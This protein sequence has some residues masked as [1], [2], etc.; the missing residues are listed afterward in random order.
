ALLQLG[1]IRT[2]EFIVLLREVSLYV[3]LHY[4][5]GGAVFVGRVR[6]VQG[7]VCKLMS[8]DFPYRFC[9]IATSCRVQAA[10]LL[11]NFQGCAVSINRTAVARATESPPS[12]W[13]VSKF[14]PP[15]GRVSEG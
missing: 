2:G 5:V 9:N 6:I 8:C 1:C 14:A 11:D 12:R 13:S 4:V 3:P 10:L 15:S 7:P